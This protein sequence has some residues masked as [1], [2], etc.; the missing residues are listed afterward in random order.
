[1]RR[2]PV[3]ARVITAVIALV[4]APVGAVLLATGGR[5]W[6]MTAFQYGRPGIDL[7]VLGG[8]ILLQ[9]VGILLLVAVVLTGIWSSA[10]LIAV[11]VL[12]LAPLVFALV[13]STLMGVQRALQIPIEVLDGVIYGVPLALFP[14]LGAM[15]L[16]LALVRRRPE[17]TA[18]ALAIV[19][20][21]LSPIL[22]LAGACLLAWGIGRGVLVA[23]QRFQ[24]EVQPDASAAVLVGVALVV[25]GVATTRWSTWALVLPAVV[26][27]VV[28]FLMVLP[29]GL[30]SLARGLPRDLLTTMPSLLLLGVGT[31]SALLYL[32]FTVVLLRVRARAGTTPLSPGAA[33][34]GHTP[35]QTT[36][37]PPAPASY[38]PPSGVGPALH[39]PAMPP[40]PPA[41]DSA[42]DRP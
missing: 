33:P 41:S 12:S 24:F 5:T 14:V 21:I 26:L 30:L 11:G 31:A 3:P 35:E 36:P 13:P 25:A 19:G 16:V 18:S 4:L 20:G 28:S 10:G 15:G 8:P 2:S 39:Q 38:F 40:Y 17:P 37:Y 32:A 27:L 22:L 42:T 7:A 9:V 23:Y 1:M 34:P 6:L 29:D